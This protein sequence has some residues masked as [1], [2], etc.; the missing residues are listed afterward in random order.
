MRGSKVVQV[1]QVCQECGGEFPIWRKGAKLKDAEHVKH[2]HCPW[3]GKVTE[4]KER[5]CQG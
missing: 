4:H 5:R 3:C 1:V 2:M